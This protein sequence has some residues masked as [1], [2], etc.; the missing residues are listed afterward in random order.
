M[1]RPTEPD[2]EH[3]WYLAWFTGSCVSRFSYWSLKYAYVNR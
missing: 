2:D 3:D 1:Q